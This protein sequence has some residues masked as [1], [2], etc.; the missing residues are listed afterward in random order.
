MKAASD[1]G[2]IDSWRVAKLAAESA[3]INIA[4]LTECQKGERAAW[5]IESVGDSDG[6]KQ[7]EANIKVYLPENGR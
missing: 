6:G 4:A 3:R 5:G 2:D 7:R 1:V